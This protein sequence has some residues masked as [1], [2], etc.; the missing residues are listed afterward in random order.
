MKN[1][2]E[3]EEVMKLKLISGKEGEA[4]EETSLVGLA[5]GMCFDFNRHSEHLFIVGTE[6]GK[7]HKCS[8]AYSGQYLETYDGHHLAVYAVRWNYYHPRIFLSASA[9]WT[10]KL[11]DHTINTPI[12]TFDQGTPVGDVAWSPFSS[13]VFACAANRQIPVYELALEKHDSIASP[14]VIERAKLTH[15]SFNPSMPTIIAGDDRGAVTYFK[16]SPNLRRAPPPVTEDDTEGTTVADK[17]I[18]RMNELLL[19][20]DKTA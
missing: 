15:I 6:E 2:L 4:E 3:P 11:W 5:G 16:L 9:D 10:V 17:L 1:K 8:K 14:K 12:I 13:T 7:I 19:Q 20:V 18:A